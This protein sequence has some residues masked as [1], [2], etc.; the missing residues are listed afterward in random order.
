MR[1]LGP[2]VFV[3]G[4]GNVGQDGALVRGIDDHVPA[5][6]VVPFEG[7]GVAGFGVDPIVEAAVVDVTLD[8]ALVDILHGVVVGGRADVAVTAIC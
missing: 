4:I 6:V 3:V 8:G 1:D 7:E 5:R 2:G